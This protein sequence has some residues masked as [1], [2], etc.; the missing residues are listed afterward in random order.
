LSEAPNLPAEEITEWTRALRNFDNSVNRS[1]LRELLQH[2]N[3]P[4]QALDLVAERPEF[5][6]TVMNHPRATA[7]QLDKAFET[8]AAVAGVQGY[9][10]QDTAELLTDI[11]NHKNT[12]PETREKAVQ[13]AAEPGSTKELRAAVGSSLHL[14][15]QQLSTLIAAGSHE[16]LDKNPTL[17]SQH[18]L[19]MV[20]SPSV[21]MAEAALGR[22]YEGRKEYHVD[23][24]TLLPVDQLGPEHIEAAMAHADPRVR[25]AAIDNPATTADQLLRAIRDPQRFPWEITEPWLPGQFYRGAE[26]HPHK[27]GMSLGM[28]TVLRDAQ[29]TLKYDEPTGT[30]T[31]VP[32]KNVGPEHVTALLQHPELEARKVGAAHPAIDPKVLQSMVDTGNAPMLRAVAANPALTREQQLQLVAQTP[33]A[34]LRT[35]PDDPTILQFR[36]LLQ[37]MSRESRMK[38]QVLPFRC[39]LRGSQSSRG[40]RR[41][42][43]GFSFRVRRSKVCW[44][45]SRESMHP[46]V[47]LHRQQG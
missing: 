8:R 45:T 3:T 46:K 41:T 31:S 7:R 1:Q 12:S 26:Y 24:H 21:P 39:P 22:P 29:R 4:M 38:E 2:P 28:S 36:R 16:G 35:E 10:D 27:I 6:K 34:E 44:S 17:K 23:G 37:A 33:S 15:E 9:N 42:P 13:M 20:K 32:N 43:A 30:D 47:E 14:S 18:L 25:F 19:Q 11:L 5:A 40:Y